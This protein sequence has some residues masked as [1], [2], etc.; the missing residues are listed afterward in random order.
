MR[1]K[2]I[3]DAFYKSERK[4]THSEKRS[5]KRRRYI[6]AWQLSSFLNVEPS[7]YVPTSKKRIPEK[8]EEKSLPDT[9]VNRTSEETQQSQNTSTS[10]TS[11]NPSGQLRREL[12]SSLLRFIN[13]PIVIEPPD[14]DQS[15]FYSLLP[16]VRKLNEDQKLEFKAAVLNVLKIVKQGSESQN[17]VF[18]SQYHFPT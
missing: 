7:T 1:W 8:Q 11:T 12:E 2:N 15:F 18:Q 6:H 10:K 17:A 9:P 5:A 16:T 4:S 3:R 13:Q 14:E